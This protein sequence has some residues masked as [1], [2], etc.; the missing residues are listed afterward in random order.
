MTKAMIPSAI[1]YGSLYSLLPLALFIPSAYAAQP[2]QAQLADVYVTAEQQL[3]QS[4]GVSVITESDLEKRP[5]VNDLSE[6]IRTMPGVNLTGNSASGQ[7]GNKRQIDIRGMGPENTLILIDGRPV[8]SRNSARMGW[9]GERNTNGDSNWVPVEDIQSIEVIRGPAAAR[10]GSGAAGGV[11]NIITKK[12]SN[13]F[14]G[15]LNYYTNQPKD[16]DEGATNRLGFNFSG[17]I[18]K[19]VLSYRIYGNYNKTDADSFDINQHT[20]NSTYQAAG[21]EGVVN[22]DLGSRFTWKIN[23]EQTLTLDSAYSRQG[24][25]YNGD[26]QN[27]NINSPAGSTAQKLIGAETNRIYRQSY[28]LT[29]DGAWD[30]GDSKL[31][32]Q[33]DHTNNNHVIEGLTGGPEGM[34]TSDKFVSSVLKTA[35]L[36]AEAHIPFKLGIDN[37][38]TLGSEYQH[39]GLNDPS[40]MT[41]GLTDQGQTDQFPGL[42]AKRSGKN[43][44]NNWAIYAEN[45]MTVSDKLKL[46]PMLRFDHNSKSGANTSPGLNFSYQA[47]PHWLLKGGIARA[48]KAPN[49]YQ[50][51][52]NYLLYTRGNG[53]PLNINSAGGRCYL[54]G[55]SNL[56]PE[57]SW[58]KEIGFEFNKDGYLASLAYFRNDYKNKIVA[59]DKIID[60]HTGSKKTAYLLQW[61]NARKAITEGL[62][63]N[64]SLPLNPYLKWVN[65]FTYMTQS[66]NKDTGNPLSVI[67]KYTVNSSLSWQ[68]TDKLD[69]ELNFTYYGRQKP[70]Q[71]AT[72]V[73]EATTSPLSHETLGSYGLWGLSGGYRF[74]K[75]VTMRGGIS[76]IFDKKIYRSATNSS[77]ASYN[78]HGRAIFGS[79]KIDL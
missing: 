36:A 4:L 66:K 78:Q 63:G 23:P 15:S 31:V 17:P 16:A 62:E 56:H 57:T 42:S 11:V 52:T 67:P 58:N 1:R 22:K 12:V 9:G 55:N 45:N 19:D 60:I 43:S 77:A 70:R 75:N 54:L 18:I 44:Q 65:N 47:H 2:D 7:R 10:Y 25:I 72:N 33:Y 53:C 71:Y 40:S 8:T 34:P 3:Q 61:E 35:R 79:M 39:D 28:A 50:S 76:N 41:T 14:H 20:G 21:Q 6:I 69:T 68:A 5:P 48:Y 51:S 27:N 29:H 37:V 24:N 73:I 46:I 13:T 74:N 26:T 32:A 49:L 64:I 59:G 30:W 38:L